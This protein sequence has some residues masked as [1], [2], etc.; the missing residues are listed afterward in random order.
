M[1]K[2]KKQGR[3]QQAPDS[4]PVGIEG[5]YGNPPKHS[6]SYDDSGHLETQPQLNKI[7]SGILEE[8]SRPDGY[9]GRNTPKP[10]AVRQAT[11][12]T[13]VAKRCAN[14]QLDGNRRETNKHVAEEG[15]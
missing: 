5:A 14:T 4:A 9:P 10:E 1:S 11:V 3:N 15:R 6:K 8:Q 7:G 2:D 13:G 12:Q